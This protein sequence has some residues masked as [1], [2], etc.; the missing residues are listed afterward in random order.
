M[1]VSLSV[2]VEPKRFAT[3]VRLATFHADDDDFFACFARH[4]VCPCFTTRAPVVFSR[5]KNMRKKTSFSQLKR[6]M[7]H[8]FLVVLFE[9]KVT[10]ERKKNASHGT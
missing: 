8:L 10:Q 3:V 4:R 2:V 7:C 6:H 1:S 5:Y 9:I